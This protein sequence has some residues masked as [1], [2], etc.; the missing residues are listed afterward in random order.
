[1]EGVS[2]YLMS[3]ELQALMMCLSERFDEVSLL[4]DCYSVMA[5]KLSKYKN[6]INDVGVTNVYGIDDPTLVSGEKFLFVK[7]HEMTPK[8]YIDELHGI[9]KGF[10]KRIFAGSFSKKLYKIYEYKKGN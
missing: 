2:M 7:E 1:M 3:K 5:A 9:E 10:F 6:P 4:M 8:K